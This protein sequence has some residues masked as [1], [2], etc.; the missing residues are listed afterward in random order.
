MQSSIHRYVLIGLA[1]IL[2]GF[3]CWLT[4]CYGGV[5]IGVKELD[6]IG[7]KSRSVTTL[8]KALLVHGEDE[9]LLFVGGKRF[10]NLR[11]TFPFFIK[12]PQNRG[13]VFVTEAPDVTGE[14]A[15]VMVFD[16]TEHRFYRI[17]CRDFVFGYGIGFGLDQVE[18][19]DG[20]TLVLVSDGHTVSETIFL[21]V[22]T[23]KMVDKQKH[24]K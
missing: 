24:K 10:T 9:G 3:L 11:G 20:E 15:V 23:G 14:K 2:T 21:N 4:W 18:R 22:K 16:F 5:P 12:T 1:V 19:Y 6:D 7:I 13:V 17:S 8:S